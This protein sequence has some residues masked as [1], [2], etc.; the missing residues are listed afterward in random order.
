MSKPGT[1]YYALI[2]SSYEQLKA[3]SS[4]EPLP[5]LSTDRPDFSSQ[6]F[7]G[8]AI[9]LDGNSLTLPL[10]DDTADPAA[11][12]A[13][14]KA[15]WSALEPATLAAREVARLLGHSCT[16]PAMSHIYRINNPWAINGQ[17]LR[18]APPQKMPQSSRTELASFSIEA[19]D[20]GELRQKQQHR[21]FP[22]GKY[23]ETLPS[24][25]H[26]FLLQAVVGE[27]AIRWGLGICARTTKQSTDTVS[28]GVG[29]HLLQPHISGKVVALD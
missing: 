18:Q 22:E 27:T 16:R 5:P 8:N 24:T 1:G 3:C 19:I 29:F 20:P 25:R 9:G 11:R 15:L 14:D 13:F 21:L 2:A 17:R 12:E 4:A 26:G 23:V 10:G 6:L 28:Y 7:S